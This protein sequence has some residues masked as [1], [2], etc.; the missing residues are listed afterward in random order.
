MSSMVVPFAHPEQD[1]APS[2]RDVRYSCHRPQASSSYTNW[3]DK[4]LHFS[5]NPPGGAHS[6][7][8]GISLPTPLHKLCAYFDKISMPGL[9]CQDWPPSLPAKLLPFNTALA[10]L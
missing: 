1:V 9:C 3:T 8:L 5:G 10:Y 4:P 6:P 2:G 7:A